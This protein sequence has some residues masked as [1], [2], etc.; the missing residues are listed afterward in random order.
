MFG[1]LVLLLVY[2]TT[3]VILIFIWSSDEVIKAGNYLPTLNLMSHYFLF[4]IMTLVLTLFTPVAV[5]LQTKKEYLAGLSNYI[6]IHVQGFI[7]YIFAC[8]VMSITLLSIPCAFLNLIHYISDDP[9]AYSETVFL[10]IFPVHYIVLSSTI[11]YLSF[12]IIPSKSVTMFRTILAFHMVSYLVNIYNLFT[13]YVLH[14]TMV[15]NMLSSLI[16]IIALCVS[17][18]NLIRYV[19]VLDKEMYHQPAVCLVHFC[20]VYVPPVINTVNLIG[21]IFITD[22]LLIPRLDA[23]SLHLIFC[24][25]LVNIFSKGFNISGL[26]CYVLYGLATMSCTCYFHHS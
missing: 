26:V 22:K 16:T 17:T 18:H 2:Y 3:C 7:Q 14:F 12:S 11:L 9:K 10:K 4:C 1:S 13:H 20:N 6:G 19:P 21:M 5:L 8:F 25:V 23:K 15:I 24:Q